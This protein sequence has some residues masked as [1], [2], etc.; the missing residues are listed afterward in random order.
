L[1]NILKT[2]KGNVASINLLLVA[3][4]KNA[5][6]N[7]EPVLLSTRDHGYTYSLYPLLDKFNYVIAG[8]ELD[9][10]MIFLDATRNRMPFGKILPDCY[11]GHARVVNNEA[12][13][14][15]FSTDSLMERK[16]T[17]VFMNVDEKGRFL[18]RL[19]QNPGLYES[20]VIREKI[21]DKGIESFLGEIK[22]AHAV[23][24][25]M[26][27]QSVDSLA[28]MDEPLAV[29]YEFSFSVD[30]HDIIYFN[31]MLSEGYK[32]NPFKSAVRRYPVEMPYT[33]DETYVLR[34][35]VPG[36][37][38]IDEMPKPLRLN[39][40]ESGESFFEYLISKSGST[41]SLRSRIKITR[42]YFTPEEYEVLREFFSL[43]VKKHGEQIVFKKK[44]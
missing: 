33:L 31:P 34:L 19:Q 2:K 1:R 39:F 9:G 3:L 23:E 35:E 25:E 37:L 13:P 11:N 20:Y 5:G 21:N 14:L 40:D 32:E 15:D 4:L 30:D 22:K 38:T 43:I 12:T 28:K 24:I 16:L 6:L 42:S 36:N 10:K 27:Q 17:S 29:Q 44:K 18:G 8:V 7:A 26:S 41:V